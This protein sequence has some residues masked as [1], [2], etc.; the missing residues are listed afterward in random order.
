MLCIEYVKCIKYW[1]YY[2]S[3]DYWILMKKKEIYNSTD[4]TSSMLEYKNV[5]AT[6]RPSVP[7]RKRS[8][9]YSGTNS[10]Q[11]ISGKLG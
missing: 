6:C 9:N 8:R 3:N 5:A 10:K 1:I 4:R 11:T 2:M 7:K